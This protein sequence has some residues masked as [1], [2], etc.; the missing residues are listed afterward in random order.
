MA[1]PF[2]ETAIDVALSEAEATFTLTDTSE[3]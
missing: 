1:V 2:K 3:P